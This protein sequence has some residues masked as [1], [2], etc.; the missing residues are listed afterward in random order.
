VSRLHGCNQADR[1]IEHYFSQRIL[2]VQARRIRGAAERF[3]HHLLRKSGSAPHT[4]ITDRLRS[5]SAALPCP[6]EVRHKRGHWLNN[7]GEFTSAHTGTGATHAS[8][9]IIQASPTVPLCPRCRP[10]L[11]SD[12]ASSTRRRRLRCRTATMFSPLEFG[13]PS[14]ANTAAT[15]PAESPSLYSDRNG[16]TLSQDTNSLPGDD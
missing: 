16:P 15:Y 1:L 6:S 13:R 11:F 7:R 2:L 8:I 14:E 10:L 3:F 12:P 9:Q 5:Y 4:V